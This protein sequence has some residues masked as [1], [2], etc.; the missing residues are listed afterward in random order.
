M[1]VEKKGTE[2]TKK[3]LHLVFKNVAFG[4]EVKEGGLNLEDLSKAPELFENLK[5]LIEFVASKPDLLAEIKDLDVAEG[6]E[7][8][9]V[10]YDEYKALKA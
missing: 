6:I 9:K 2:G 1:E 8:L 5:E 3:A 7:L 4:L 10:I